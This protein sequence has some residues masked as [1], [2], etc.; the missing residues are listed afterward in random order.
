MMSTDTTEAVR[1]NR[2]IAAPPS[3]IYR[4]WLDPEL[5][6]RW[7]A[8]GSMSVT[9]AEVD[10]RVGGVFRIWQASDGEDAGGF[11]SEIVELVPDERIVFNWHFV[12]PERDPDAVSRLTITLRE[13]DGGTELTLVH[14]RLG[15]LRAAL[16]EVADRVATGWALAL[17]NLARVV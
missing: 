8:A 11:E 12:G 6:R 13:V 3:R 10:E 2:V 14:E 9:R 7:F 5:L 1:L 17:D 15:A 4:A 16:P